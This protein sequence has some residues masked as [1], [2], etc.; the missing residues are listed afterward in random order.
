MGQELDLLQTVALVLLL[1]L[2]LDVRSTSDTAMCRRKGFECSTA[3]FIVGVRKVIQVAPLCCAGFV[4]CKSLTVSSQ[5]V[6]GRKVEELPWDLRLFWSVF[7]H[8]KYCL[9]IVILWL[10]W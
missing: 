6:P 5:F 4:K 3:V 2:A 1:P 10:L 8:H 9:V 7:L